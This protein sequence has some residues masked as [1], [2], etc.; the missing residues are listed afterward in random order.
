MECME[1]WSWWVLLG[2]C[3]DGFCLV[4]WANRSSEIDETFCFFNIWSGTLLEIVQLFSWY[5]V[6]DG[7]R[8]TPEACPRA[9]RWNTWH[10]RKEICW[11]FFCSGEEEFGLNMKR[12]RKESSK[13]FLSPHNWLRSFMY[14]WL[15][16]LFLYGGVGPNVQKI[17]W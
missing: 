1:L 12:L 6:L 8:R 16:L 10:Y 11:H 2:D 4:H 13:T 15:L 7:G 5:E 3:A 14:E 9:K 17:A